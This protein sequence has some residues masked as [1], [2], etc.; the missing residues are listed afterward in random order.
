MSKDRSFISHNKLLFSDQDNSFVANSSQNI[1]HYPVLDYNINLIN[2]VMCKIFCIISDHTNIKRK[3]LSI[4]YKNDGSFKKFLCTTISF[5]EYLEYICP[6]LKITKPKTYDILNYV[7]NLFLNMKDKKLNYI[8]SNVLDTLGHIPESCC[9]SQEIKKM[10]N[11]YK[12]NINY[13]FDIINENALVEYGH[14]LMYKDLLELSDSFEGTPLK[15]RCLAKDKDIDIKN[16]FFDVPD[17]DLTSTT[18]FSDDESDNI[19]IENN[20]NILNN[21][22]ESNTTSNDLNKN[23]EVKQDVSFTNISVLTNC[24]KR[25]FMRQDITSQSY[26]EVYK[27]ELDIKFLDFNDLPKNVKKVAE[28]SFSEVYKVDD[29]IYKIVPMGICCD[30][31][32]EDF[33]REARI[34]KILSKEKGIPVLKDVLIISGKYAPAYLQAWDDYGF[35]E[36]PR[37]DFYEENQMYG[38]LVTEEG[39]VCLEFYKF[40]TVKEIQNILLEIS[41]ILSN[42]ELKY[43]LEHRDLHWGNILVLDKNV[44]I[45][46]FAL[47]RLTFNEEIIFKNLN[48]ISWIFDGDEKVDEQFG[49]YKKMN[50]LVDEDWSKSN[51]L[52]TILWMKYLVRKL[53]DKIPRKKS[54]SLRQVYLDHLEKCKSITEFYKI[55]SFTKKDS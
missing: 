50:R 43:S 35:V 4:N 20:N 46:D 31:K 17:V 3:D 14:N 28:A 11:F 39:G 42:L 27:E 22:S 6:I 44:K 49:I 23:S 47:S 10:C 25:S 5:I 55:L 2:D 26:I 7:N 21:K 32:I 24:K 41:S 34:L 45:I 9:W 1:I 16:I 48:E 30:T 12:K 40:K 33:I 52:T 51:T 15:K 38:V 36:N 19:L 29:L 37:P 13:A 54:I 8:L 18:I 53:F